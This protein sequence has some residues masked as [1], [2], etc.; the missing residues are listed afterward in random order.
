[1]INKIINMKI[2][3]KIIFKIKIKRL[4]KN[5]VLVKKIAYK[6]YMKI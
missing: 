6:I 5:N 4:H 3:N 1:M 2:F